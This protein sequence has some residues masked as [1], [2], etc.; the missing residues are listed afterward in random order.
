MV[1]ALIS[2]AILSLFFVFAMKVIT[3]KPKKEIL[4]SPHG[5]FTC[6]GKTNCEFKPPVGVAFFN[7]HAANAA[8]TQFYAGYQ[9]NISNKL[10]V[11][12]VA[13]KMTNE[14]GV[15]SNISSLPDLSSITKTVFNNY[16][17]LSV[18]DSVAKN[19]NN[20]GLVYISW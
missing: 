14:N 5:H 2:M 10:F 18:S 16:L 19:C 8:K 11:N 6:C 9:P 15:A 7:V 20:K 3:I 12:A 4:S 1:E 17:N 13:Q